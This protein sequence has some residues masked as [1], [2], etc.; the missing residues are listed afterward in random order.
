M[1]RLLFWLLAAALLAW[2]ASG[3]V[4]E[5]GSIAWAHIRPGPLLVAGAALLVAYLARAA[6]W[7]WLLR[8]AAGPAPL[9][10][11]M[12][13]YLASQLGRYVPGK[14]W[15]LAGAGY[16]GARLGPS[17]PA[18]VLVAT[19]VMLVHM[20]VGA[21]IGLEALGRIEGLGEVGWMGLAVALAGV[22]ALA[23]LASPLLPRLLRAVARA[24]GRELG[25]AAMPR[26]VDLVVAGLV[27]AG[28]WLLFGLALSLTADG[29]LVGATPLEWRDATSVMAASAFAGFVVL[30][31]PS[32]LGVREAVMVA[33]LLPT[34]SVGLAG[35]LAL[36][37]R[38]LMSA[39]ELGLS[40]A[41]LPLLP[42]SDE[43]S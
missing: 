26:P 2:V 20:M 10:G 18:C 17:A 31:A 22:V 5:A 13:V 6:L 39:V 30:V 24:M 42:P 32:G 7:V 9:I 4:R 38:L 43:G 40:A 3:I 41:S 21:T 8:R 15:T 37:S 25:D 11:G 23:L 14:V 19:A 29:V 27:S 28:V 12:A 16:L 34:H 35:L 33:A 1:K 36:S